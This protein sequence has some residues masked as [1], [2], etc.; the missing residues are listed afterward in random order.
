[1]RHWQQ[2]SKQWRDQI[3]RTEVDL[4]MLDADDDVEDAGP[5]FEEYWEDVNPSETRRSFSL[6]DFEVMYGCYIT[7]WEQRVSFMLSGLQVDSAHAG[8]KSQLS[9]DISSELG[10]PSTSGPGVDSERSQRGKTEGKESTRSENQVAQAD[11]KETSAPDS[12]ES[13]PRL[14]ILTKAIEDL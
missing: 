2:F 3:D 4:K 11:V 13:G 10:N 9:W 6:A 7:F 5:I 12:E 1:L 14:E 8:N